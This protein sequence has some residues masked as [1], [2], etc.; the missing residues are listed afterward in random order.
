MGNFISP[1][2][3]QFQGC[4]GISFV[5]ILVRSDSCDAEDEDADEDQSYSKAHDDEA[6]VEEAF[7]EAV[8]HLE[9]KEAVALQ[10]GT[11]HQ[12]EI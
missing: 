10:A 3:G 5:Y 4:V 7:D 1:A 8:E 2:G 12:N 9:P 11:L 6:T